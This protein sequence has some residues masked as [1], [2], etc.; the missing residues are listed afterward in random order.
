[1]AEQS[2]SPLGGQATEQEHNTG[3]RRTTQRHAS[4]D[5][6]VAWIYLLTVHPGAHMVDEPSDEYSAFLGTP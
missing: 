3:K 2:C 4:G 5:P 1:M 6:H